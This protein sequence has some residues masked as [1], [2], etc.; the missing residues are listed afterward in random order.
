[1]SSY[2][3][4]VLSEKND[5]L[6]HQLDLWFIHVG[7]CEECSRKYKEICNHLTKEKEGNSL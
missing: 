4:E 5:D 3:E 1:M 2:L 7:S 6:R